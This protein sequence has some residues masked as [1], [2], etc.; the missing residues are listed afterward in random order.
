MGWKGLHG[1]FVT[2]CP[3]LGDTARALLALQ[4]PRIVSAFNFQVDLQA[5]PSKAGQAKATGNDRPGRSQ[6]QGK[7][8][9]QKG[10]Q[11]AR[12]CWL[13]HPGFN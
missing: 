9:H 11:Y 2:A 13:S 4:T 12:A 6:P 7:D 8:C 10:Q 1:C 3:V 5:Q